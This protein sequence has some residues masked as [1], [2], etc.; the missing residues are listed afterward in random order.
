MATV[1]DYYM[2]AASPFTYLGHQPLRAVAEM[3][4]AEIRVKPVRL[5]DVWAVSG[6]L[7]PPERPP[8]RQRQRLVELQ[9][10]ADYRG[11]PINPK[12]KH[13]PVDPTLADHTIIAL[14]EAGRDPLSFMERVLAGVWANEEDIADRDTLARFLAAEGADASAILE[15]ADSAA[16]A[17]IRARNGEEAIAADVV[18]VPAY[19][20]AGEAFWGQDRVEYLDHALASGRAPFGA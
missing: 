11:V 9:R 1:I 6:A 17:A 19:V 8:V 18:G 3:H 5:A 20:L 12:P 13:W 4:G 14:A 2:T 10:I 15:R 7:P 16:V